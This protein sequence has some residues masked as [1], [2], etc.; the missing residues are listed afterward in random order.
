MRVVK[1]NGKLMKQKWIMPQEMRLMIIQFAHLE[2]IRRV[3]N[4]H[5]NHVIPYYATHKGVLAAEQRERIL[6]DELE[7]FEVNL[8]SKYYPEP[9]KC[10]KHEPR[11]SECRAW[12]EAARKVESDLKLRERIDGTNARNAWKIGRDERLLV[13]QQAHLVWVNLWMRNCIS[14]WGTA[15]M[16]W[17]ANCSVEEEAKKLD[18]NLRSPKWRKDWD[19][20]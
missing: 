7:T 11:C 12:K 10:P 18:V 15:K 2:W 4:S 20:K 14:D 19:I 6:H 3:K 13:V 17:R 16:Q 8:K 1:V 5:E 9:W